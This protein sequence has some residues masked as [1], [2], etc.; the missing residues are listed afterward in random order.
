MEKIVKI[1]QWHKEGS[2]NLKVVTS[3]SE[4][5]T[6]VNY[7]MISKDRVKELFLELT[8]NSKDQI[9]IDQN[10]I[11]DLKDSFIDVTDWVIIVDFKDPS[12]IVGIRLKELFREE[13]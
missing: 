12:N 8:L 5:D 6:L 9:Y 7:N 2:Y 13:S 10:C 3:D 4:S 11:Q 1:Q